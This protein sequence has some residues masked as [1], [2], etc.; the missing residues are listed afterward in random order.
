MGMRA[1]DE[2]EPCRFGGVGDAAD[3]CANLGLVRKAKFDP[4]LGQQHDPIG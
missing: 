1:H 2:F 4:G 3:F